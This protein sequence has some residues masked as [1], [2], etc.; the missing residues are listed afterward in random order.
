MLSR[1]HMVALACLVASP[2]LGNG[3]PAT[4]PEKA[5]LS[6]ERLARIT[7][8]FKASVEAKQLPGAVIAIARKGH[9]GY[10]QAI[11]YVDAAKNTPMPP[12]AI[13][14]IASMTKPMVS[15]GIMMLHDE[16]KLFLSDP[17]GKHLPALA[18]R[19]LGVVKPDGTLELVAPK[20]QPTVQDLLRHTSGITYGA[21][22]DTPVHKLT[23]PSSSRSAVAYTKDEFIAA[24]AKAPLLYEP[25]TQWDYSLSTD[26][27]GLIVEAVSGQSLGAFLKERIWQPLGMIDTS[28][29]VPAEKQA[30]YALAFA[31][32]PI[33]AKPQSVVHASGQPL[34]FECGGGCAVASTMDYLRFAQMLVN[35]GEL[36]GKRIIA[37]KTLEMMT[38]D[39]LA[40][41]VRARTTS[42]VLLEGYGFGLGFA[43]RTQTGI[44]ATNGSAGDY[45]WGGAFGTYFWVDPKEQM[46]A[47]LMAAAP[48]EIRTHNRNL[49]R[50]LVLQAIAD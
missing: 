5:G 19:Q 17:I 38:A 20:R 3:I 44:A 10:F 22:G 7:Q 41:S 28:F 2:A 32:D 31:A 47:V 33:T 40:P 6:P 30:R 39:Q 42:P 34:K 9:L 35:G 45:N 11:G 16:G 37:R 26:V 4:S 18:N 43:V 29:T 27:L 49:L 14:S 36:D 12:D 25:G 8:S 24:M 13:F 15:I 21:R 23:P 46:V 48:G 50:N 1:M